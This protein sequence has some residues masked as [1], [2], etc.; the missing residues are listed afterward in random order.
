MTQTLVVGSDIICG[1]GDDPC[2]GPLEPG[3][4]YGVRYNLF[5]GDNEQEFPFPES[6]TFSTSKLELDNIHSLC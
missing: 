6:V 3:A 5:S 2:N 1:P 4:D